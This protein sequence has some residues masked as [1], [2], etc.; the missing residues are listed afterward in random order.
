MPTLLIGDRMGRNDINEPSF[1]CDFMTHD[2]NFK[3]LIVDYPHAALAFFAVT[4]AGT[5][6]I[7]PDV[8]ALG[9]TA[10]AAVVATGPAPAGQPVVADRVTMRSSLWAW[11]FYFLTG[12]QV[13]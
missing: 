1:P 9:G 12:L 5:L 10:D 4:L 8:V 7:A 13:Y 6:P 11:S 2:Q 3:N